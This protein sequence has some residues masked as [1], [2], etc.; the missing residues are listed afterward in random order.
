VRPERH[1]AIVV[2]LGA[3]G[4]AALR[5]LAGRG[6]RALG[7]DRHEP[8]HDRGSSHGRSRVIRQ[9]YFEHPDYVPLLR[10]AYEGYERLGREAGE[11][12]LVRTG[13]LFAGP[14]DG[15]VVAGSRQAAERHAIP[16]ELLD[17]REVARRF[18]ALRIPHTAVALYEPG[19]GFVRAEPTVRAQVAGAVRAGAAVRAGVEVRAIRRGGPLVEIDTALGTLATERLVVA[20][21]P[22]SDR[23]LGPS[24]AG[25]GVA[26]RV[27]RQPVVWLE[28]PAAIMPARH[29]DFPVWLVDLGGGRSVYGLPPHAALEAPPGRPAG[30]RLMKAAIHGGGETVDPDRVDRMVGEAEAEAI[31]RIARPVVPAAGEVLARSVC[32]YTY[33][34]DGHFILDRDPLDP[35]IAIAGGFSGHGFKFAPVVGEILADLAID[36]TTR[37]PAAFLALARFRDR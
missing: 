20:A 33:S 19:A 29:T 28:T 4:S 1:E 26:L 22:W 24:L 5:S 30:E 36:G 3:M 25:A 27:T 11:R 37:R 9:A 18:P 17:A 15:E 6:I 14:A 35:R 8:G 31:A 7:L 10:E 12:L 16:H 32:L 34:P 2:G 13:G 23:L 21:G